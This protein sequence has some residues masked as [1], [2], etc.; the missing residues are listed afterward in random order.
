MLSYRSEAVFLNVL[1][2]G[3]AQVGSENY[4]SILP[5]AMPNRRQSSAN[6]RVVFNLPFLE[7]HVEIHTRK[8][9]PAFQIKILDG[10]LGH[11]RLV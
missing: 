9:S 3:P 5:D 8:N 1:T 6:A 7:R 10:E 2:L 4:A 11:Y